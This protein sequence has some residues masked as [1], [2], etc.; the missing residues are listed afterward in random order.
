[1]FK[2]ANLVELY[3]SRMQHLGVKLDTRVHSIRLKQ[4]LLTQ[5]PDMHSHTN[6]RDVQLVFEDDVGAALTKAYELDSD[7]D[8]VHLACAAHTMR[9]HMFEEAKPFN[10]L[11]EGCQ[12][13][14]VPSLLLAL[15]S[16]VLEGPRI[17]DQMAETTPAA[18][19]IAQLLKFNCIKNKRAHCTTEPVTARHSSAQETPVPTYVGMMVFSTSILRNVSK[20]KQQL[21]SQERRGIFQNGGCRFFFFFIIQPL[22]KLMFRPMLL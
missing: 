21:A 16:M 19:A 20:G 8:V 6:R 11:P 3:Q 4:R 9:R 18:L 10:G 7:N 1:M 17:K 5:F 13:E 22:I 14:S 15:V 12:E 2:L